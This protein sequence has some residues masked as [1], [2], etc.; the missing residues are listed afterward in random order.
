MRFSMIFCYT[1]TIFIVYI[2]IEPPTPPSKNTEKSN[3]CSYVISVLFMRHACIITLL[4]KINEKRLF[5][6]VFVLFWLW[7]C[8]VPNEL[9]LAVM[10]VVAFLSIYCGHIEHMIN[11][12]FILHF[13]KFIF[14]VGAWWKGQRAYLLVYVYCVEGEIKCTQ[15]RCKMNKK[16]LFKILQIF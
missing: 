7:M 1:T 12:W 8:I 15:T 13:M 9:Q 3:F 16:A 11:F 4:A 6:F 14:V 2:H 5:F 10:S